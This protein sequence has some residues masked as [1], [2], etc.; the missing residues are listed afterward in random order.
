MVQ[1]R[2]T[3]AVEVHMF[4]S[5]VWATDGSEHADRA[6]RYVTDLA[7]AGQGT[8]I[9]IVHIAETGQA[10]GTVFLPRHGEERQVA[11]QLEQTA[12]ELREKGLSVSV[13]VRDKP[14]ARPAHEI[15]DIARRHGADLIVAGT[16]GLS[17]I[18]AITLGSVTHRLL[19][20]APCPVLVVPLGEADRAA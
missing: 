10:A 15:A 5:I 19:H 1:P 14:G 6:L 2:Q 9:T 17:A 4:K 12:D 8:S 11:Q 16:R 3:T 7:R 18:G 20:I 13:E